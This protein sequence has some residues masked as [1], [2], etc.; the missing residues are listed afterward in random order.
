MHEAGVG[1]CIGHE[2]MVE[3]L[4]E[5]S[6]TQPT[7]NTCPSSPQMTDRRHILMASNN[8]GELRDT[9]KPAGDELGVL[10]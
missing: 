5:S 7:N 10:P 8:I 6:L 1:S 2:S 3:I 4:F 9:R